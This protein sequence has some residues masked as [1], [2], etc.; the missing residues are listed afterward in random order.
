MNRKKVGLALGGGA[1]R[2]IA[3][4]GVLQVF[5][6]HGIPIDFMSGCS[7]GAVVGALYCSGCDM[8]MLAKLL[9]TMNERTFFDFTVP[10]KGFLKGEKAE[11]LIRVFT[12]NYTFAD[13]SI[14]FG[15]VACDLV[16]A[17]CI[18]FDEGKLHRAV[19]AS[20][21]IPGVFEPVEMGDMVLADGGVINRVPVDVVANMGAEYVIAVD[22]AFRGWQRPKPTN[23]VEI[24]S[25]AFELANWEN[26]QRQLTDCD[27]LLEPDVMDINMT[28]LAQ[29]ENCI[30]KGRAA[31]EAVVDKI[32]KDL[33]M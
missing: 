7:A 27:V 2:G 24:L 28:S 22:V 26:V 19:R 10:R 3:H 20:I 21:S 9:S 17:K 18:T 23:I 15:V 30:K 1:A 4:I 12:K 5:T 31:A 13:C 25:Q 8:Y 16:S 29:T 14:P 11:E 32:K 6:E 33:G